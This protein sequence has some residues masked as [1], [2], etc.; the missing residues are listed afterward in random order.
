M[1]YQQQQHMQRTPIVVK[2]MDEPILDPSLD[3]TPGAGGPDGYFDQSIS[4][5]LDSKSNGL[6]GGG[7]TGPASSPYPR[8]Q[9]HHPYRRPDSYQGNGNANGNGKGPSPPN[10]GYQLQQQQQQQQQHSQYQQPHDIGQ[11]GRPVFTVPFLKQ[12]NGN[13]LLSAPEDGGSQMERQLSQASNSGS[14]AEMDMGG[15]TWQRW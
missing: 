5:S 6:H 15:Q 3:A 2:P 8:Y 1:Q 7:S 11:D 13:G 10:S 14:V 9:Q 12:E 4:G